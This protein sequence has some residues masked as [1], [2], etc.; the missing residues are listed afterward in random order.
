MKWL[1]R[2]L[3][4]VAQTSYKLEGKQ[5]EDKQP[6]AA[7]RSSMRSPHADFR[8]EFFLAGS[9]GRSVSLPRV[10]PRVR[11]QGIDRQQ[12]AN[13]AQGYEKTSVPVGM[14]WTKP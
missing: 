5:A 10:C 12:V 9:G 14:P 2:N 4:L 8:S 11:Y 6:N 3:A 7:A 1:L 13:A